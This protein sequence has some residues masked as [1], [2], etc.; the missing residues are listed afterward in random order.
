MNVFSVLFSPARTF[1]RIREQK[2]GGWVLALAIITALTVFTVWLQ[3][4]GMQDII[5]QQVGQAV[6]QTG[7]E[8]DFM[9]ETTEKMAAVSA[10][11]GAFLG[12]VLGMFFIGLLLLLVNLFVRGEAKYMQLAKVALYSSVPG[13]VGGLLT[14]LLVRVTGTTNV[15]DVML[16]ASAFAETKMGFTWGLLS[17]LDPFRIWGLVLMVIGVAVMAQ[18]PAGKVA[19]WVVGGWLLFSLLGV[20]LGG[21]GAMLSGQA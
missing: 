1:E 21:L 17:M 9:R 15:Y 4:P 11:V 18:R 7:A 14:G 19:P 5:D 20:L 2:G 8:A 12:P 3:W 16:N 13:L 6:E 10:Y